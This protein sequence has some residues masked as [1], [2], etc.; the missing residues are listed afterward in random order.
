MTQRSVRSTRYPGI[1]KV[2]RGSTIRYMV[3]YRVRGHGQRTKTLTTLAEARQFQGRVRNPDEAMRLAEFDRGRVTLADYFDEWLPRKRRLAESTLVRYEGV[4]RL[5]I[6]PSILGSMRIA[7]IRPEHVEA[8]VGDLVLANTPS[9]TI[10][11]AYR[12]LRAC[13]SSAVRDGKT[14]ANPARSIELPTLDR[15][16]PFFLTAAQVDAIAL[17]LNT[18]DR[19]LTYFLAYTGARIGEATALRLRS[20]DLPRGRVT[21]SE[22]SP[23]V[24]GRKLAPGKTKNGRVRSV[25]IP[26]ALSNELAVHLAALGE[27]GS[28]SFVFVGPRGA[29][30]RQN[31]WRERVFQPAAIRGG[32][33]RPGP[34]GRLEPPRV[35][36]LRHTF[37]S[38]A[39]DAGYTLHEVKEM[40]GHSTI[41]V[42][43]DLYMHLFPDSIH[44][45]A[46]RLGNLIGGASAG[47][48][49]V[50]AL[51]DHR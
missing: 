31:N 18:G 46:E 19:A 8:W 10:D 45:K 11:K 42:T 21:I 23:E 26:E 25:P 50:T 51:R 7:D 41:Q 20:L 37:A 39:A 4:G 30:I 1:Y 2:T 13:L 12:T 15:R 43:S 36:D 33:V 38:L 6:K 5:Y 47:P 35:H 22:N 40:L 17:R 32:V 28:E 49:T 16:E 27:R 48:A 3:S 44:S 24:A 34:A 14:L 9:F 29:P